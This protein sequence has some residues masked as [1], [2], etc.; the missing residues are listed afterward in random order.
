M[1]IL[2]QLDY[3]IIEFI[4]SIGYL[5]PLLASSLIVIEAFVPFLPLMVFIT[6]NFYYFG[7]FFG[8]LI[9]LIL[10]IIG[11]YIVFKLLR[12][13]FKSWF[14]SKIN[15]DK[16]QKINKLMLK[17]DNLT[18]EQLVI[19]MAIPFT[20]SFL[21]NAVAGLSSVSEKKFL[22]S[23]LIGKGFMVYFWGFVGRSLIDSF[24][25]PRS[26]VTIIILV[27]IAFGL[28]KIVNKKYGIE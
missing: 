9:S 7:Y 26:L 3:I 4:N 5:A 23:L 22:M 6:V 24:K 25:D 28:S 18:L 14:D 16:Y 8:F 10:T 27:L 12:K 11:S 19:V 21:I 2:R 17:V 20:P 13:G 15:G 1:E